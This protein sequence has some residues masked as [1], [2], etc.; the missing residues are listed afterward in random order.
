MYINTK[1]DCIISF[2]IQHLKIIFV[3]EINLLKNINYIYI[4]V[5]RHIKNLIKSF[6]KVNKLLYLQNHRDGKFLFHKFV[7]ELSPF[8]HILNITIQWVD[9]KQNTG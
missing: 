9:I 7:F 2:S 1:R 3:L 6:H 4:Y 8:A 5:N